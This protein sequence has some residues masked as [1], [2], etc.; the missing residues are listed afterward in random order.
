VK[1]ILVVGDS[2]V[3]EFVYGVCKRLNPEAPTPIFSPVHSSSNP[4]MSGNVVENLKSLQSFSIDFVT[5]KNKIVKTRYVEENSNYILLRIDENDTA[6]P[7]SLEELMN[8]G[9]QKYDAVIVSDYNK[10]FLSEEIIEYVL[11]MAR[12]S[13]ID[14]KKPFGD[15]IRFASW[16]KVNKSESTNPL[17]NQEVLREVKSRMII[18]LGSGGASLNG[19]IYPTKPAEVRDVVGAGDTFMS[20]LVAAHLKTY[21]IKKSIKFANDCSSRVVRK[22]GVTDMSEMINYYN[23]L[24]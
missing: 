8:L 3:D 20:A 19:K 10:G 11:K 22:R 9:I 7:V 17:H 14:T 6:E 23:Q 21:D 15:W 4:G 13:F 16:I 24:K 12:C 1:K 18:T 2:C 5:N